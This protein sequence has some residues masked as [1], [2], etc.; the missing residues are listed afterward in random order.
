[1]STLCEV[2]G[3]ECDWVCVP[4]C[5]CV[6]DEHTGLIDGSDK[7]GHSGEQLIAASLFCS[8]FH[9]TRVRAVQTEADPRERQ[10]EG[11]KPCKN[12]PDNRLFS[13]QTP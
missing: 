8:R 10:G 1:M 3:C 4:L 6:G 12:S 13:Q 2:C 11:G 5:V 7:P 9:T